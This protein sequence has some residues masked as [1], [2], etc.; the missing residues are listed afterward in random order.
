MRPSKGKPSK[1]KLETLYPHNRSEGLSHRTNKGS[2]L[3]PV[4]PKAGAKV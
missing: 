4:K 2:K 3:Q 1:F